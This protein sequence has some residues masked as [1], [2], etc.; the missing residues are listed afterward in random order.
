MAGML[1]ML[2]KW[3][4]KKVVSIPSITL[5]GIDDDCGK[6]NFKPAVLVDAVR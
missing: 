6:M 5:S 2:A 1:L 4:L 3:I